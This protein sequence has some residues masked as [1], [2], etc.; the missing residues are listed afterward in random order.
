MLKDRIRNYICDGTPEEVVDRYAQLPEKA[1]NLDFGDFDRNI[2]VLDTETTGLSLSHD[3]LTQIAAAKLEKGEIVDWFI[4]FVNPGKPI[5]DDVAHLTDIHDGDV[6]DAPTPE[7]ALAALVEFVGDAKIVAHNADFDRNFTTKHPAGYPLLEN[8]WLDSLDLARISLPRMKSHRLFDLVK[9]FGAPLSTHRADDDVSSTCAL[10]RI[11]LAAISSMPI[12]LVREISRMDTAADWPTV[13]VFEHFANNPVEADAQGGSDSSNESET[14]VSAVDEEA[15]ESLSNASVSRETETLELF[16]YLASKRLS[17]RSMRNKRVSDIEFKPKKDAFDLEPAKLFEDTEDSQEH[18]FGAGQIRVTFAGKKDGASTGAILGES[19]EAFQYPGMTYPSEHAISDAFSA[20]GI[21]GSRF[22]DY[23]AREEQLLMSQA[24]GAAFSEDSNLMVEAGTGVG[25]SMAYLLPLVLLATENDVNVGVATKTNALLDQLVYQELPRL[26]ESLAETGVDLTYTALKG[27]SHY[28][29]LRKVERI[30]QDGPRKRLVGTKE[31]SQAPALAALVSF[32]EQ[33]EYD[34]I[35]SLKID[36]RTLPKK[37]ITTTSHDCMRRK[38]P[39]F[40]TS[41]FVHGARKKAEASHVVVTNHSLLFCDMAADNCLLPPVRYWVVD[42]AHGAENEARRAFSLELVAEEIKNLAQRA[43]STE[44]ARN[45]F[46]RVERTISPN[47]EGSVTLMFS[48]TTKAKERGAAFTAAANDFCESMRGLLKFDPSKKS[49][50]YESVELWINGTVRSSAE[51]NALKGYGRIMTDE[52]EKLVTSCQNLVAYL[53]D[54]NNAAV[55]QREIAS[56]AMELKDLIHAAEVILFAPS[57]GYVYST[58]LSKRGDRPVDKLEAALFNVGDR[59]EESFYANTKSVVYASATLAVGSSFAA[60]EDSMG[61]NR[62][63]RTRSR[64]LALASSYD[65]DNQM[66]I[67]VVKDMPEPNDPQYLSELQS[68]LS[69]I[70]VAQD[71]SM[72]TLFTN[73]KEMEKCFEA[74]NPV[75]K[76]HDLRLVCQKWGV[77]VKGLR[78]DFLKDEHLSLFALRSFWEGFD[79]PGATLRGVVIPKLPF[80]KPTDPLS[81]ERGER[82]DYAWKRYVLPAAILDT[83]QAAGRLIRRADDRGVLVLADKRLLTKSYGKAFL[84]AMPSKNIQILSA[85]EIAE[86][87]RGA[88]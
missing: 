35:D 8:L 37:A 66:T 39:F 42:E 27:F 45:V 15:K 29:C 1:K 3:E 59:L 32:I 71:G 20:E 7:E 55:V 54:F 2:V 24:I 70:H 14:K 77:S 13:K 6:C 46:T 84:N 87:I 4:T 38:C 52:A 16:P 64:S 25:K 21:V 57:D 56:M 36:Y 44:S 82:D 53:E 88:Q 63:G 65:F 86:R 30:I 17:M 85:R 18:V 10:Y 28:P 5:P 31:C 60:F 67:Y 12:E 41:C 58:T 23:E 62:G 61:L 75:L 50:G 9:A 81:C 19:D 47:D 76:E 73:R 83:K 51:F 79:A 34:D 78:D 22:A 69:D 80:A 72:L 68:L 48:L 43:S 26:K 74:V 40:G 49:K 33:T 11:L